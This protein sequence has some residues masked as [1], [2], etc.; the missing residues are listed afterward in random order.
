MNESY[1]PKLYMNSSAITTVIK[2]GTGNIYGVIVNSHSSGTLKLWDTA[3][4]V[5]LVTPVVNTITFASGSGIFLDLGGATFG[6]GLVAIR[7]GTADYT[8]IYR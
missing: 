7:G 8:F 3:S 4:S 2:A 5:S 1:G 6:S